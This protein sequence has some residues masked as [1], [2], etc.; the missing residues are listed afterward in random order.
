V[1][2]TRPSGA[3]SGDHT[4]ALDAELKASSKQ[5]TELVKQSPA[6][7]L[8]EQPGVGPVTAA[9]ALAAWSHHGRL[10]NEAAF[11]FASLAGVNP[12][13]ASSG[14]TVR[15]RINRGGDRRLNRALHMAIV[16]LMRMDPATCA[17][18]ERRTAGGHT[19]KEIRRCLKRYLARQIYRQ[20]IAAALNTATEDQAAA[21]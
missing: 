18:V 7:V 8:L 3:I 19:L 11:A 21:A 20:L 14:N 12:I 16:T 2:T 15:H 1:T 5:I 6:R 9:V 17:Y 13:P 4:Q 10:R